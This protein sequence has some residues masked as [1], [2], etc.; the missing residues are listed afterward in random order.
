MQMDMF[1]SKLH[2]KQ[3]ELINKAAEALANLGCKYYIKTPDGDVMSKGIKE[4]TAE[5]NT[6][7]SKPFKHGE[8]RAYVRPYIDKL[9]KVGDV[10][11]IPFDARYPHVDM[12]NAAA[13]YC[14][15]K[16]G[17]GQYQVETVYDKKVYEVM[18]NGG[19]KV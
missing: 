14:A 5:G 16:L 4:A 7:K 1:E 17:A 10:V 3:R 11:E 19:I 12:V 9:E 15:E 18:Y 6:K 13:S 8:R 2:P